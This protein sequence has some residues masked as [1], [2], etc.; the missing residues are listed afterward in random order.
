MKT[1]VGRKKIACSTNVIYKKSLSEKK[2]KKYPAHQIVRKKFLMTRNHPQPP[3]LQ[4]LNGRPLKVSTFQMVVLL[5]FLS[6]QRIYTSFRQLFW[7]AFSFL[8]SLISTEKQAKQ[9]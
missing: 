9:P 7:L 8:G 4:E 6:L 1:F 5:T 3:P 2:G